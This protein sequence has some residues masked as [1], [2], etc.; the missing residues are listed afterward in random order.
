ML[1]T[2][3]YCY[4]RWERKG[5]FYPVTYSVLLLKF[6]TQTNWQ[7]DDQAWDLENHFQ[8]TKSVNWQFLLPLLPSKEWVKSLLRVGEEKD[9]E[10]VVKEERISRVIWTRTNRKGNVTVKPHSNMSTTR[11]QSSFTRKTKQQKPEVWITKNSC[12]CH[13]L[14][15]CRRHATQIRL[16]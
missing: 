3:S 16:R 7:L 10:W 1:L 14:R 6:H 8:L 9:E 4:L 13:S 2:K 15:L 5:G 12:S 11:C